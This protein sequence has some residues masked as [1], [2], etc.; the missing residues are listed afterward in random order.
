MNLDKLGWLKV[1]WG[2]LIVWCIFSSIFAV[3]VISNI[4]EYVYYQDKWSSSKAVVYWLM[5]LISLF[6][7]YPL[8]LLC[9]YLAFK[10]SCYFP[11][12]YLILAALAIIATWVDHLG[13]LSGLPLAMI[14]DPINSTYLFLKSGSII[15]ITYFAF[16]SQAFKDTYSFGQ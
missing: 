11:Y 6:I 13:A 9:A 2:M 14:F 4:G 7:L 12:F 8:L 10:K 15:A 1:L 3:D 5:P 16:R